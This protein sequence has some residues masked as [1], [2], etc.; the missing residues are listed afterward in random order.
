MAEPMYPAPPVTRTVSAMASCY[1]SVLAHPKKNRARARSMACSTF[2]QAAVLALFE[3]F[4]DLVSLAALAVLGVLAAFGV[5]AVL[6]GFSAFLA[7]AS[8]A[9][10]AL[11]SAVWSSVAVPGS[12]RSISSTSAIGA[13]SPIRN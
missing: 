6:A 8:L 11:L 5:L 3:P 10:A 2:S 9:A 1:A 12:G 4:A 7:F 13:L